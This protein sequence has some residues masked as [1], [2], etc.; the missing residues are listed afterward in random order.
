[1]DILYTVEE[2]YLQ[3]MDELHYGETP[4]AMHL[5]KELIATDDTYARAY[6]GLG[7]I[8]HYYIKDYKAAGYYYQTAMDLDN[9][10]PDLYEDYIKLL[11]KLQWHKKI[12]QVT[13]KIL[14]VPGINL[15]KLYETLGVYEEQRLDF[16]LAKQ[17]YQKAALIAVVE[18]EHDLL[19]D[20]LKR[21]SGKL[22]AKQQM[23]YAYE[24]S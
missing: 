1:M 21:V 19:Q 14:E 6:Y 12:E 24:G 8:Y 20:H 11:V 7:I 23:V 10:I 17:Y 18:K 22:K 13:A 9:A 15:A 4:K 16:V 5:L 2:K 3:A